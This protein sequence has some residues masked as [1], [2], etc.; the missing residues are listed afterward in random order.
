MPR[1]A[2]YPGD[3]LL[4]LESFVVLL[5]HVEHGGRGAFDHAARSLG[6][7]R[8]VLRRRMATL[9]EWMAIRLVEGRGSALRATAAGT[10]LAIRA[11]AMLAAARSLAADVA[12]ARARV[13]I[14]C[15]GTITTE[16]LPG[17]VATL[18]RGSSPIQLAVRRA[19][20]AACEELVLRG[21][22][23]LGIVRAEEAPKLTGLVSQH[24]ADDRLW[25]VLPA[26]HPLATVR[27]RP[28]LREMAEVPLILYR[29]SSRTRARVM[30]RLEAHGAVVRAE[31][32]GKAAALEWVR[33]GLGGAFVSLLPG[34]T[35]QS[36]G[37]SVHD[38]TRQF[39]ASRFYVVGAR[40]RWTTAPIRAVVRRLL[41]N[42]RSRR[43]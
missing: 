12:Q 4:H 23:D 14:A 18:E 42:A 26:A 10:R 40:D 32:D 34:H 27:R 38:V 39:A 19:G 33:A 25:F 30:R 43:A 41:Q 36:D 6:V 17:V 2:A 8:S 9:A 35:V 11:E 3:L 22:V 29:A 28:S 20:G 21:E 13:T 31:V 16:L 1:H 5:R 37:L 7:D 24:L 15:T